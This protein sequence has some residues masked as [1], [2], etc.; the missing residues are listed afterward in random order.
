VAL[1][2]ATAAIAGACDT[3]TMRGDDPAYD[4]VALTGF[5][6][7]WA[8]GHEIS[9]FVDETA[10]TP[11]TDLLQA[12]KDAIAA[13]KDVTRLGEL[14]FRITADF[15]DADVIFR[16]RAAP[17]IVDPQCPLFETGGGQTFFCVDENLQL[18]PFVN[19]DG[20]VS[21]V[22]MDV[23]IF[24]GELDTLS[25]FPALVAHEMGHVVGIGAH[26]PTP[27]DLMYGRPRRFTPAPADEATLRFILGH[28]PD[29]LF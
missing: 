12:V 19:R 25:F 13:W 1:A 23:S 10:A 20:S 5:Y 26:S 21:T 24:P 4:P 27:T 9:I 16:Y 2:I 6:Y 17:R 3:P 7:H 29:V 28:K 8:P 11:G 22:K 15:R 14:R 18:F